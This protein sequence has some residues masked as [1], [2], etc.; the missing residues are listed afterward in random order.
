M[1][2]FRHLFRKDKEDCNFALRNRDRSAIY[3]HV[4]GER[5]EEG[6]RSRAIQRINEKAEAMIDAAHRK[7]LSLSKLSI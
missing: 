5:A 2:L 3:I 7:Q 1:K 4:H 6:I